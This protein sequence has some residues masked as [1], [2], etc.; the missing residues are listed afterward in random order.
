MIVSPL[1]HRV[2][3]AANREPR[4]NERAVDMLLLHYTGMNSAAAACDLLC[5]ERGGF[6]SGQVIHVNGGHYMY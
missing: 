1:A 6:I 2:I 5:S 3:E 4:R